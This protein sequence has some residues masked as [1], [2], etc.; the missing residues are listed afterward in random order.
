MSWTL[1]DHQENVLFIVLPLKKKE[2]KAA[3]RW[4]QI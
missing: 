4:E 2:R 3:G 1:F